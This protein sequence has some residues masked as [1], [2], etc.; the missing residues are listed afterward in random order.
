M[1]RAPKGRKSAF[2]KLASFRL[3]LLARLSQRHADVDYR[4]KVGLSLLQCRVLGIVGS[5]G[6][7]TFKNICRETGIEKSHASRVVASLI[8]LELFHKASDPNDQRSIVLR[9]T[10][11]GRK[12]HKQ[13][14]L[15]ALER[16]DR[17]LE[18]LS[19]EQRDLFLSC[20]DLLTQQARKLAVRMKF[21]GS[22]TR[23]KVGL[24]AGAI[25]SGEAQR[26]PVPVSKSRR[27][28]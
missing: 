2:Q 1:V 24:R 3:D 11:R 16:N 25:R 23:P 28:V 6:E 21:S 17:W 27:R 20:I 5:Q 7:M 10:A 15:V 9:P 18:T 13:V 22:A 19:A 26:R 12:V 14:L 8:E 4:R